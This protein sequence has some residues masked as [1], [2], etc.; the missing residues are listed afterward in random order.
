M[1]S[2]DLAVVT[3]LC[4]RLVVMQRGRI[5]ETLASPDL[6]ARRVQRDYTRTLMAAS[7][8]FRRPPGT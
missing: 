6:A 5:V 1:V 8:G 4:E 3:H 7:E 2:H